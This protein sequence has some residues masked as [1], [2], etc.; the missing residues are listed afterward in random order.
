MLLRPL[1]FVLAIS[2]AAAAA[3]QTTTVVDVPTRGVTDRILVVAPSNPTAI[4]VTLPGNNGFL[5]IQ[6]DGTMLGGLTASCNPVGRNR[7]AL[8]ARR[9][10]VVLVDL[11]ADKV[12]Y[13]FDDVSAVIRYARGL[14]NVPVYLVGGS[15][16]TQATWD[17][18]TGLPASFPLGVVFFSPAIIDT[19]NSA[20][21]T[22]PTLVV[23]HNLDLDQYAGLLY[24][25]L[26]HAPL[27]AVAF[28]GGSFA[29]CR[30]H[31]FQG[32]DAPF[33]AAVGNFIDKYTPLFPKIESLTAVEYYN[34]SLDH[35][36]LTHVAA[37]IAILDAGTTIKGWTRTGQSF[38][39]YATPSAG[40]S[41]VCRFYI[42]PA[43]GDS[44]FYGRGTAE[45]AATAAA[46]PTF[47]N[48]DA[49]FF[50]MP[51]PADG[52]CPVGTR[53]VY[54][55]FSNRIDANHRYMVDPALRDAMAAKGW[56]AEGD[57]PDLV[58]MCGPA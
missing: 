42:P 15:N 44:H 19:P 47:V 12:P 50:H 6:P 35:Y 34:A 37:E 33:V 14:A 31:L 53:P 2:L 26:S 8:A 52:T 5:D 32:L 36:F 1:C 39:V 9:Y 25:S 20:V 21:Y 18:A 16:S 27:E 11:P 43:K 54:R 17:V 29:G 30:Y 4:V 40:T 23:T 45:C 55:A 48:E 58:V 22:R 7:A 10:I 41:P 3:A 57:G 24:P 56:V 49:S 28:S 13:D 38:A 46:N 51:L